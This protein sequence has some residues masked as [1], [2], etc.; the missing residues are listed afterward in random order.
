MSKED[1]SLHL[2]I[3]IRCILN[4]VTSW[5]SPCPC[6]TTVMHK[7]YLMS[8]KSSRVYVSGW[9]WWCQEKKYGEFTLALTAAP[10]QLYAYSFQPRPPYTSTDGWKLYDPVAEFERMGVGKI[11]SWR[12]SSINRD[13][14]VSQ[15]ESGE[16][17]VAW[18]KLIF[19]LLGPWSVLTYLSKSV[20]CSIENK[21]QCPELCRKIS[22]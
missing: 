4:V 8:S 15:C 17:L 10:E 11:D 14:S 6:R 12:F 1:L 9:N 22:K 20:G 2:L 5:Y 21:W 7:T 13:Y 16:W 18:P 3:Y 19:F